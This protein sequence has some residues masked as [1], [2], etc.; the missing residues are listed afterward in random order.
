MWDFLKS[1]NG[2]ITIAFVTSVVVAVV[3]MVFVGLPVAIRIALL[4]GLL[5]PMWI[6]VFNQRGAAT[7]LKQAVLFVVAGGLLLL[8]LL[9]LLVFVLVTR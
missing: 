9:V 6:P 2:R 1:R 3:W 7:P 8:G 4:P 5:Y